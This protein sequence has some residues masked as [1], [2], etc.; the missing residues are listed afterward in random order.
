V[1]AIDLAIWGWNNLA[2]SRGDFK[3]ARL[4]IARGAEHDL[5]VASALGD[6]DRVRGILDEDQD[7]IRHARA[8]GGVR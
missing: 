2:P 6:V 1:Q 4:L 3:T 8:N 7:A 5:T